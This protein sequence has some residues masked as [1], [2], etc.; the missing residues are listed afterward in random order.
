ML[1]LF[2]FVVLWFVMLIG[3]GLDWWV[4]F[5]L[6]C[7]WIVGVGFGCWCGFVCWLFRLFGFVL[8][9][10]R[11][12]FAITVVGWVLGGWVCLGCVDW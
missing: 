3:C 5:V 12:T 4:W 6:F 1:V 10:A 11:I 8:L 7:L 9:S 2:G